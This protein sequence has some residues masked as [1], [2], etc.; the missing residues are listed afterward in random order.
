MIDNKLNWV[1]YTKCISRKIAKHIGIIITAR[2]SFE[3][4]TLHNLYYALIFPHISYGI[5]VWETAVST[6]LHR[7][8]VLQRK[9]VRIICGGHRRTH[10]EPL[11][12]YLNILN[13]DQIQDYSI[14]LFM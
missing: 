3:S 9:I 2:K 6:H 1:E 13:I 10:T 11:Y 5:Q 8:Y 7:L 14:A 4:E 12:K